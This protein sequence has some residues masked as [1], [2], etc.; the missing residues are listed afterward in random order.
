MAPGVP[1]CPALGPAGQS[2]QG[3]RAAQTGRTRPRPR[4]APLDRWAGGSP[5]LP[6]GSPESP[7][8]ALCSVPQPPRTARSR[9]AVS[10]AAGPAATSTACR[11]GCRCWWP[12]AC[13]LPSRSSWTGC[14][15]TPT[16]SWCAG[17][18]VPAGAGAERVPGGVAVGL[19]HMWP[20]GRGHRV[21]PADSS[22]RRWGS[23]TGC[24]GGP[25]RGRLWPAAPHQPLKAPR[26][27]RPLLAPSAAPGCLEAAF[28]RGFTPVT[29]PLSLQVALC[30]RPE[31][32]GQARPCACVSVR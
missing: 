14:G 19:A 4:A 8:F 7:R 2:V 6:L 30:P 18:C 28:Q 15:P 29:G 3:G 20:R 13:F 31:G 26:R 25:G 21:L 5:V 22:G 11:S 16:S 10:P 1:A 27:W 17:R 9:R 12:K 23:W 32:Q 24:E